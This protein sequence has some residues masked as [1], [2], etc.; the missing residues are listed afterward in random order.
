MNGNRKEY[1]SNGNLDMLGTNPKRE[2]RTHC[3]ITLVANV[4]LRFILLS[5]T[6]EIGNVKMLTN[7]KIPMM[8]PTFVGLN[9]LDFAMNG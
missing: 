5:N 7:G 2:N 1:I 4:T 3:T 9:P 6:P 8:I